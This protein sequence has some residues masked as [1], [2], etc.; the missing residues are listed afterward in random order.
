MTSTGSTSPASASAVVALPSQGRVAG[1]PPVDR[2]AVVTEV[3]GR[4]G[5][6]MLGYA[7]QLCGDADI[8]QDL[9]QEALVRVWR[10]AERLDHQT[11]SLRGWLYTVLRNLD[12]DRRR[13]LAIRP[14]E[15]DVDGVSD[16][17]NVEDAT[18]S[19]DLRAVEDRRVIAELLDQLGP[20]ERQVIVEL[21]LRDR[22]VTDAAR[23]L[24]L[25]TGTVKSRSFYAMRRLR[26]LVQAGVP[27]G[28]HAS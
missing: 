14:R 17:S 13:A 15:R 20:A 3:L 25:P 8:A 2:T 28:G 26:D 27:S 1:P 4:H 5:R 12:V 18:R 7:R 9:V 24:H 23:V 16:L 19:D 6:A 10:H 22:T 21:Y 11:G